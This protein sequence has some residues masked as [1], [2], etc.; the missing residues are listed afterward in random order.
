[1][2]LTHMN[3]VWQNQT[4]AVLDRAKLAP[5]DAAQADW[6][7]H[8]ENVKVSNPEAVMPRASINDPNDNDAWSTRYIEDGSYLRLKSI[9]LSY[10][11]DKKLIQKAHLDNI[12]LSVTGNNIA[13]WTKYTGYD[14]EIGASTASANVFG[15]DNGRYPSPMSWAIALNIAF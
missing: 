5:I 2:K 10:T 7:N 14:P 15:L 8:V 9:S 4:S 3:S 1:M 11:F 13:T 6:Y 12:R